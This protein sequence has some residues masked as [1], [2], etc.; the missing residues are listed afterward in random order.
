MTMNRHTSAWSFVLGA[1]A[2]FWFLQGA[3]PTQAASCIVSGDTVIDSSYIEA[4]G[5]D[6]LEFTG[7]PVI[8]W[9]GTIDTGRAVTVRVNE[10]ATTTFDGGLTLDHIGSSFTVSST[11]AVIAVAEDIGGIDIIAP[12]IIIDGVLD[13]NSQGC[14]GG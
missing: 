2:C 13:G 4:N 8:T 14:Q 11:G 12:T 3:L 9:S 7:T 6:S 5:C 1:S 10:N